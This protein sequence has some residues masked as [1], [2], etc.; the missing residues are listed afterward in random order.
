MNVKLK[1]EMNI[2]KENMKNIF[3]KKANRKIN[4]MLENNEKC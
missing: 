4:L 3:T 2:F 1:K